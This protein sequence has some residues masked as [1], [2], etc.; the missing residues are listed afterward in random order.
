MPHDLLR[1]SLGPRTWTDILA[2]AK[3]PRPFVRDSLFCC[4]STQAVHCSRVSVLRRST[5]RCPGAALH[6]VAKL[7]QCAHM[8]VLLLVR[9]ALV[10]FPSSRLIRVNHLHVPT[11]GKQDTCLGLVER[12]LTQPK[13]LSHLWHAF[14]RPL[15]DGEWHSAYWNRANV[16]NGSSLMLQK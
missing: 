16:W 14:T 8:L 15:A 13:T 10:E 9:F 6:A 5:L 3:C 11:V 1:T 2:P 7:N 12:D 4:M